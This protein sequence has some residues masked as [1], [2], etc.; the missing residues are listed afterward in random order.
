MTT[1]CGGKTPQIILKDAPDLDKAITYAVNGIYENQGQACSAGSRIL[2][3]QS[4]YDEVVDQFQK[5]TSDIVSMGHPFDPSTTM[6]SLVTKEH[7][8][9]VLDYIEIGRKGGA[10]LL[11]GGDEGAG[12]LAEGAYV[13]PFL[14]TEVET[15]MRIAQE[16]IFGPV[17][18]MIPIRD[19]QHGLEIAND[20][21][22]GLVASVWTSDIRTAHSFARDMQAGIVWVNCFDYGDMTSPWGGFKQSGNGRDKCKE[23]LDQYTQTKSVWVE[24]AD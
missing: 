7:Q 6:G 16:E 14:F 5:K 4:I 10:H 18:G 15:S 13:E 11:F 20:S 19:L 12:A 8:R 21:A 2:V 17:A 9:R 23:T 22:F 24:L 1:E 3:E